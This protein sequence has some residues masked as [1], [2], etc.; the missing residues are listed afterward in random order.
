MT[1]LIHLEEC[2]PES[3]GWEQTE[4]REALEAYGQLCEQT[5][6]MVDEL[7]PDETVWLER[8]AQQAGPLHD[9]QCV[10]AGGCLRCNCPG[11]SS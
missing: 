3:R 2:D 1:A 7:F 9:P 8:D 4:Y 10:E 11:W 6:Y 5:A